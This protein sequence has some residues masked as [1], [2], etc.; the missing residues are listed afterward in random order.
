MVLQSKQKVERER[1]REHCKPITM[2][3]QNAAELFDEALKACERCAMLC[4]ESTIFRVVT[5]FMLSTLFLF[6]KKKLLK[7]L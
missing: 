3:P 7:K 4:K 2:L 5:W 6:Q 1:K